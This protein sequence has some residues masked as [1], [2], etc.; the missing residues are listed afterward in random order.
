MGVFLLVVVLYLLRIEEQ[1]R[2]PAELGSRLKM[3]V[4]TL[5]QG[6]LQS[7]LIFGVM[8]APAA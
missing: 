1:R 4:A 5:T 6:L 8:T 7:T 2:G 3:S